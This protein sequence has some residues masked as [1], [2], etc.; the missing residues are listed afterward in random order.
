MNKNQRQVSI[1]ELTSGR[2]QF[3]SQGKTQGNPLEAEDLA[4][5]LRQ[6]LSEAFVEE[7]SHGSGLIQKASL[8]PKKMSV[9]EFF[10]IIFAVSDEC[11][12]F[13]AMLMELFAADAKTPGLAMG[14]LSKAFSEM[15]AED[16]DFAANITAKLLKATAQRNGVPI[17]A[18]VGRDSDEAHAL[19]EAYC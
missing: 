13:L 14:C 1:Q 9:E 18:I 6:T 4:S 16:Q 8:A 7:E 2:M 3:A 19:I 12:E 11:P 17:E 10:T 15:A 5:F